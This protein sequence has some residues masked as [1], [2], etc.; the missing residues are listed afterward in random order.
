MK[1]KVFNVQI[2]TSIASKE[3]YLLEKQDGD[4]VRKKNYDQ[5]NCGKRL[6]KEIKKKILKKKKKKKRSEI[7]KK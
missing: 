7:G 4:E 6:D 3:T 1:R 5:R 2:I